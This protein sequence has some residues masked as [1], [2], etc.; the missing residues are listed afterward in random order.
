MLAESN[1]S[2][3]ADDL[4]ENAILVE[5]GGDGN[6]SGTD[7][8]LFYAGGPDEWIPDSLN[9]RFIHRKNLYSGESY[10]YITIGGSGKRINPQNPQPPSNTVVDQFDEHYFHELDTVN[11]L[12]S[13]K[14]WYG[15]EFSNSPGRVS[16]REFSIS[17]TGLLPGTPVTVTSD[18][19]ARSVGQASRFDVRLNNIPLFEHV[20]QPL[21]GI[22]YEPI[23]TTS[24]LTGTTNLA[25]SRLLLRYNFSPGSVNSQGWLNWFEIFC[26]PQPGYERTESTQFPSLEQCGAG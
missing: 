8:F 6:F 3:R 19:I 21:P 5:D 23:A 1:R 24:Q 13:G 20:L 25:E 7:Y 17:L 10:Y 12:S 11:F 16:F 26:T 22:L 2:P 18:V 9:K 14:Q 15:E 4:L